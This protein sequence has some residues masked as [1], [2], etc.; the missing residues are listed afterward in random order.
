LGLAGNQWQP[1]AAGICGLAL[2]SIFAVDILTPDD[3]L[4]SL[5]LPPLLAGLWSFSGPFAAAISVLAL[6]FYAVVLAR[7]SVNRLTIICIGV[8]GVVLA[9]AIR[10]YA[11]NLAAVLSGRRHGRRLPA[12]AGSPTM[13][14]VAGLAQGIESLTNRELEVARLAAAGFMASEIGERLHISE[15][16]VE[17]HLAHGYAK[18]GVNSR[19]ALIQMRAELF[20]ASLPHDAT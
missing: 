5:G 3:V 16:T 6:A 10:V 12:V 4:A 17:T 9:I 2:S 7:E 11:T 18:L 13:A 20:S 8:A 1:A 19:R 15:R 14:A